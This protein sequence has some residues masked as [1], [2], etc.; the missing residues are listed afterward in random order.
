MKRQFGKFGAALLLWAAGGVACGAQEIALTDALG[1][2]AL[3]IATRIAIRV[4]PQ[5][6]VQAHVTLVF[7]HSGYD[8]T[9]WGTPVR[10]DN[11]LS[12]DLAIV[13]EPLALPVITEKSH[14]YA[15]GQLEEGDYVFEVTSAGRTL[16]VEKFTVAAAPRPPASADLRVR[17]LDDRRALAR[18]RVVW[19]QPGYEVTDWGYAEQEPGNLFTIRAQAAQ[20]TDPAPAPGIVWEEQHTYRLARGPLP[21]GLYSIR[22]LLNGHPLAKTEFTVHDEAGIVRR[23]NP[24][25]LTEPGHAT[26]PVQVYYWHPSGIDTASLGDRNIRVVGPNGYARFATLEN[27]EPSPDGLPGGIVATYLAHAPGPVWTPRDKGLYSVSLVDGAVRA[28]SGYVFPA[29]RLGVMEVAIPEF[30]PPWIQFQSLEILQLG[31]GSSMPGPSLY[32]ARLTVQVGASNIYVRWGLLHREGNGFWVDL[33]AYQD[34]LVGL[35]V[36][37]PR[38]HTYALGALAPGHYRFTVLAYGRPIG[39]QRFTIGPVTPVLPRAEV[40]AEDITE[41]RPT[42]HVFQIHYQYDMD[43]DSIR[44]ARV[45]VTGPQGYAEE[46]ELVGLHTDG[47]AVLPATAYATYRVAPPPPGWVP[48]YNGFYGIYLPHNTIRDIHGNYVR[49]GL[50][51]GFKVMIEPVPPPGRPRLDFRIEQSA[52]GEVVAHLEF[53]PGPTQW[54]VMHWSERVELAGH[55]F[56]AKAEIHEYAM[57]PYPPQQKSYLLGRLA[58]GLY[59]FVWLASNG[60]VSRHFFVIG[61]GVEPPTPYAS[62]LTAAAELAAA[63][64]RPPPEPMSEASLRAYAFALDPSQP[65]PAAAVQPRLETGPDGMVRLLVSHP[66]V[67]TA[68]DLAYRLELSTDL[69]EWEDGT[70]M[71]DVRELRENPDGSFQV[72]LELPGAFAEEWPAKWRGDQPIS[73]PVIFTRIRADH[74]PAV[75]DTAEVIP[76][77]GR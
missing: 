76:Q 48:L 46:A 57:P 18:V 11:R 71:A 30:P 53:I 54:R 58:P 3:P 41:P 34:G 59:R 25:P 36:I 17:V 47:P 5:A 14:V 21:P 42:A 26:H 32:G 20:I 22:F 64:G 23:V 28:V 70:G 19:H 6:F 33:E 7:P 63:S 9:D 72:T 68:T 29:W 2:P 61:P 50:A 62:W 12:V 40:H 24:Q 77:A 55:T 49:G 31:D 60:F 44:G 39:E 75:E 15:L 37:T 45:R 13:C 16:G 38:T 8:V 27:W 56:I 65:V 51:G 1:C 66:L 73:A 35:D 4:D 43:L 74:R 69:V 52:T 10:T 67:P